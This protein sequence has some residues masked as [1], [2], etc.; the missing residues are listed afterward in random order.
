MTAPA[1]CVDGQTP[2]GLWV[3]QRPDLDSSKHALSLTDVDMI[4]HRFKT[5][6]DAMGTR[7]F[8]LQ[9]WVEI[10]TY[11][12]EL[13]KSQHETLFDHHQIL[14]SERAR[15]RISPLTGASR[16]LWHF[17]V[18]VLKLHA[19]IPE[20]KKIDWGVFRNDGTLRWYK[21]GTVHGLEQ[22]LRFERR[23]DN[24]AQKLCLRRHH[25]TRVIHTISSTELGFETEQQVI[26][27]S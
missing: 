24:P 17:G 10:K 15:K 6:V 7:E 12:G 9:M 19:G 25:K 3:R 11:S 18:F 1:R 14:M 4:F 27:R 2:F 26:C 20:D 21:G 5:H 22:I 13:T 23:P 8:Q 16:Y